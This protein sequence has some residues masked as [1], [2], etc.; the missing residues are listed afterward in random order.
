MTLTAE[1]KRALAQGRTN[2]A[3]VRRY[4]NAIH[5]LG[6][7]RRPSI[8]ELKTKLDALKDRIADETDRV[9]ALILVQERIDLERKIAASD[10]EPSLESLERDFIVVGAEFA[11]KRNISYSA[12]RELGVEA[13]VLKEAGIRRTRR[14]RPS[15]P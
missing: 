5:E 11:K 10:D 8:E 12:Y 13:R 3:I 9:G 15:S 4:L 2:A 14:T 1:R 7:S 6:R